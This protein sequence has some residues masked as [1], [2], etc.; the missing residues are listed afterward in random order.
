MRFR[1]PVHNDCLPPELRGQKFLRAP[2]DMEG[3]M[4]DEEALKRWESENGRRWE[5]RES[6][7]F[8]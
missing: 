3:K 8:R 1:H 2:G 6:V 4:W 7:G 5:G